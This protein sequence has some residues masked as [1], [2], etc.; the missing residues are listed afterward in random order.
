M[1]S[2]HEGPAITGIVAESRS[3]PMHKMFMFCQPHI[4]CLGYGWSG[5]DNENL[6]LKHIL[7]RPKVI[8]LIERK[9]CVGIYLTLTM[10]LMSLPLSWCTVVRHM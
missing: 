8:T 9:S 1:A 7:F 6:L 2:T 5:P 10:H 4:N 3:E